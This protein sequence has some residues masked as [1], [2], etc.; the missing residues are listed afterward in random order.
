MLVK[1][2]T[3][4]KGGHNPA[5]VPEGL[6][7]LMCCYLK[8][9]NIRCTKSQNWNVSRLLLQLSLCN[10][11]KLGV[12]SRMKLWLEQRRQAMLQSDW[13]T[14]FIRPSLDGT[15][16]GMALSVRPSVRSQEPYLMWLFMILVSSNV[17]M[18]SNVDI[19]I[20][21]S[22]FWYKWNSC[23]YFCCLPTHPH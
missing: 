19:H 5:W 9:S 7:Y 22:W 4:V 6:M 23:G 17:D 13:S 8:I 3:G 14:I 15:Y 21:T 11:L 2:A 20:R 10:I 1:E 12:K 16:Y 18:T